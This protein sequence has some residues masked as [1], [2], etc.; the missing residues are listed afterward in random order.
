[1]DNLPERIYIIGPSGSGKTTMAQKLSEHLSY[2]HID[3]DLVR[4]KPEV[5]KISNED[6]QPEVE[7]IANM[8]NWVVEGIYLYWVGKILQRADHIV[9]L[10]VPLHTALTRITKR[11][12]QQVVAGE[13]KRG[14]INF[15]KFIKSIPPHYFDKTGELKPTDSTTRVVIEKTL[16]PYKNKLIRIKNSRDLTDYIQGLLK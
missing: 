4:Y 15:L 11:Y 5:G 14:F 6:I 7:R 8:Q 9:W 16:E 13:E 12:F 10:D 2:P 1:M 3:L